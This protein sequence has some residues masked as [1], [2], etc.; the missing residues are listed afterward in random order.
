MEEGECLATK[1]S[2]FL[3]GASAELVTAQLTNGRKAEGK[4]ERV[5]FY[6]GFGLPNSA[7]SSR[8]SLGKF[9]DLQSS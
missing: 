8:V 9:S 4:S 6:I 7:G 1:A 5:P 3:V 2:V